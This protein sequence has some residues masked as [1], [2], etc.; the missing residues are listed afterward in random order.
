MEFHEQQFFFIDRD[1]LPDD[2]GRRGKKKMKKKKRGRLNRIRPTVGPVF[3]GLR[4]SSGRFGK[5]RKGSDSSAMSQMSAQSVR[6]SVERNSIETTSLASN[7]PPDTVLPAVTKRTEKD[8]TL[9][10]TSSKVVPF[11]DFSPSKKGTDFSIFSAKSEVGGKGGMGEASASLDLNTSLP[12]APEETLTDRNPQQKHQHNQLQQQ[13]QQY[14]QFQ[15]QQKESHSQSNNHPQSSHHQKRVLSETKQKTRQ[16]TVEARMEERIV[17]LHSLMADISGGNWGVL[18]GKS[19][20]SSGSESGGRGH[21][22]YMD[23]ST[24]YMGTVSP[25]LN[26]PQLSHLAGYNPY[27]AG[28]ESGSY[29]YMG[30]MG[31]VSPYMGVSSLQMASARPKVSDQWG[32]FPYYPSAQSRSSYGARNHERRHARERRKEREMR[33]PHQTFFNSAFNVVDDDIESIST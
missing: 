29:P 28:R 11:L 15:P 8:K 23:S 4:F 22:A 26:G 1:N 32:H 12:G 25:Y 16:V 24:P 17:P 14:Y 19:G 3:S 7:I 9:S 20:S 30:S 18:L 2:I 10:K 6:F 27:M 13:Q 21:G 33:R 31:G 5:P